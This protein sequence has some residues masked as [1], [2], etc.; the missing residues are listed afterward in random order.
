MLNNDGVVIIIK[1]ANRL[2]LL[3]D[4]CITMPSA[5]APAPVVESIEQDGVESP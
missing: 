3:G 2:L 4:V 1:T 5:N